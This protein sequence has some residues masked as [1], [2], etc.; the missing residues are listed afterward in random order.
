[1]KNFI[2]ATG[3]LVLILTVENNG[4]PM[5]REQFYTPLISENFSREVSKWECL[6]AM[7]K[8]LQDFAIMALKEA[9]GKMD[10]SKANF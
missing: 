7:E 3:L 4:Y 9:F 6:M 10:A 1:M 2:G 5:A 8:N